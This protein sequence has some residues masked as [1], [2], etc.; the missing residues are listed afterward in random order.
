MSKPQDEIPGRAPPPV[1]CYTIP[2]FCVAHRISEAFF[3]QLRNEGHGPK[4]M[5]VG[6]RRMITLEAAAE[7]RRARE[8][9]AS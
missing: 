7:W 6:R 4:E 1:A 2:E 9:A 8:A 5:R 3:F